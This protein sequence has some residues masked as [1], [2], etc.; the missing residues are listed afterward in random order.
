MSKIELM[1]GDCLEMMKSLPDNGISLTVTSP[2]Y[3]NL[4]TYKSSLEWSSNVWEGVLK[5]LYRLTAEGGVVVWVVGDSSIGGGESGSS[6][7]QALYAMS[8]G[9]TLNDTMIYEKPNRRPR[10]YRAN[11]YEQCFEYMFVFVKGTKSKVFNPLTEPCINAGKSINFTSRD[12]TKDN[13]FTSG[14]VI[15][16]RKSVEVGAEKRKGNIWMYSNTGSKDHP[17]VFP[18]KLAEDHILSWS[19]E[20]DVVFD[21]F[22]GSGTTG[23]MAVVHSRNFIGIEKV[24]NYFNIAEKRIQDALDTKEKNDE[25]L[26]LL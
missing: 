12:A 17:A 21:P 18:E 22:M 10:Q 2:P 11:R 16:T 15:S 5:E 6:F 1:K 14:D 24:D 13:N 9:F 26:L 20:G 7:K 3:D 23:K 4:R 25:P 19:N 8:C